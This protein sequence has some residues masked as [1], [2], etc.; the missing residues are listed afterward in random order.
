MQSDDAKWEEIA[1]IM[2]YEDYNYGLNLAYFYLNRTT[3][4][5]KKE[6]IKDSIT[7][8]KEEMNKKTK[9]PVCEGKTVPT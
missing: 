7:Q 9:I 6:Q 8:I 4:A 2:R 1:Y 5:E 3:D